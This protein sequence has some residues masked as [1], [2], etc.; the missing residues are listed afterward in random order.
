LLTQPRPH[1]CPRDTPS[2]A[3]RC[4]SV[5]P[6]LDASMA[7][8]ARERHAF[9]RSTVHRQGR[10]AAEAQ[11]GPSVCTDGL[12]RMCGAPKGIRNLTCQL[13]RGS[14]NPTESRIVAGH[15]ASAVSVDSR[16]S[17]SV[18][19]CVSAFH[20]RK[21]CEWHA[22]AGRVPF[23]LNPS[24]NTYSGPGVSRLLD[25]GQCCT[26]FGIGRSSSPSPWA[27]PRRNSAVWTQPLRPVIRL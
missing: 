21:A 19:G 26:P 7:H 6:G 3:A 20:A 10:S 25:A 27:R 15:T 18:A 1:R 2:N 8:K 12:T 5:T 17:R 24:F 9:D 23:D 22:D 14:L 11:V 13:Q 16:V 4:P